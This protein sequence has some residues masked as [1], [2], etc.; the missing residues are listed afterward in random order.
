MLQMPA[1]V[2]GAADRE[3]IVVLYEIRRLLNGDAA[4]TTTHLQRSIKA[5]SSTY[6]SGS[7]AKLSFAGGDTAPRPKQG[8]GQN[9][10]GLAPRRKQAVDKTGKALVGAA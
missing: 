4:W 9:R 6:A 3:E 5:V 1:V 10:Q 2:P 7:Y 8:C